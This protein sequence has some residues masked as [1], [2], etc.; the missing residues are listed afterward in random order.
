MAMV[1]SHHLFSHKIPTS[2]HTVHPKLTLPLPLTRSTTRYSSSVVAPASCCSSRSSRSNNSFTWNDVF[3]VT[4]SEDVSSDLQG[5]FDKIKLCNRGSDNKQ[6]EFMPFLIEDHVLG[7][8]HK[9][10]AGHLRSFPDVF[11]FSKENSCGGH[12]GGQVTLHSMLKTPE[13]RTEAVG[14]VVKCLGEERIPGIKNEAY[15]VHM[16][17]YVERDGQK[18][19]WI[20]K[21]SAVKSNY[22]GMLDHLVA[23]GLPRDISCQKNLVK[24]C[25][26]EAGIPSTIADYAIPVGAVS[27]IDIDGSN[28]RR[29]VIFCYDLKLPECFIPKN[30]DGEV[31]SFKLLPVTFVANIIRRSQFFK[32]NCNLTIIDFL[33]RHGVE[34][35]LKPAY[36]V[37]MNGYV[38][39]DGQKY[40]WIA[41]RSAVKSNYPGMLDHLVAGGLPRDIS[42]Q[43]NLVKE[44][45]EEAGIPSTI[46]DYA[47]PVGA[48]SYTDI[49][50]CNYRRDVIFCYD[51]KLPE[52][53]I[54]KNQGKPIGTPWKTPPPKQPSPRGAIRYTS[55]ATVPPSSFTWDDVF[56]I[57]Q[58]QEPANN[59]LQGFFDRVG[60][61]NRGSERRGEFI[62]FVIEGQIVGYVHNG[63]AD[64]LRTFKDVFV[65]PNDN[66][67][68]SH[69][70]GHV[71]L[72]PMLK[73][74]DHRTE[75]VDHVVKLLGKE[76]IPGIRNELYPVA[77]SFGT[78]LLFSLER[79]AAPYFGIKAYGVHMNGYVERGG[80]KYLWIGKR[81]EVKPTYPGMLDHLVAGG[82]SISLDFVIVSQPHDIACGENLVKECEEEAG[83][84][85]SIA[86]CAKPV[87]AVSYMDINGYSYKRDVLFCYD[88][89][90]PESFVPMNQDGEVES[91]KLIPVS[92]VAN[93]IQR[94]QFFKSN[95][96]LVIIDFLFRHGY[97]FSFIVFFSSQYIRPEDPGYLKLLQ[98]LRSGDCS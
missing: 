49:D 6:C 69:S 8:V 2:S 59:D 39:R 37:H 29:D 80:E 18:Y 55:S 97:L 54:P 79:G 9:R 74:P 4:Q 58:P 7:Y 10:F 21:R 95:C 1:L 28:Y 5:F 53:F 82:L 71:T 48:V 91:F 34:I 15:E 52:R 42:C 66:S 70:G 73:T 32:A 92:L 88:L 98:S 33:F 31:E 89:K 56:R 38:E 94:T 90:L 87:G 19:L 47:I 75:A 27:Y 81:S 40:L 83:I 20:A 16:N 43:K 63:F 36:E 93:V 12:F 11:I 65:F 68:G 86:I 51:L 50:G 41:K 78:P 25:E 72:H 77:P 22:P 57:S 45:E 35:A 17:G 14:D 23:G 13:Q 26:E 84:P 64:H 24:E 3:Q 67:N 85:K 60:T 44:C 62:P 96:N 46:A 76:L 30:Q 61:C